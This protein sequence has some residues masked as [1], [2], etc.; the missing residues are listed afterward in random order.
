MVDLTLWLLGVGTLAFVAVCWWL[1][2]WDGEM[3]TEKETQGR[4]T[5]Q[6]LSKLV[7]AA[8]S[9]RVVRRH[10]EE[11]LR[12]SDGWHSDVAIAA[13]VV[14]DEAQRRLDALLDAHERGKQEASGA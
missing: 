1:D 11:T 9:A 6:E 13:S 7:E 5:K 3:S 12:A 8:P 2:N 4:M 14:S 10:Y